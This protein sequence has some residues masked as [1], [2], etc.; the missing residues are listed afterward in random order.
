SV[1]GGAGAIG[2]FLAA[3]GLYGVVAFAVAARKRELALRMALGARPEDVVRF[4]LADSAPPIVGGALVGLALAFA[5]SRLLASLLFGLSPTDLA[6]FLGVPALLGSV[7]L[8]AVLVPARRAAA[9]APAVA[10]RSE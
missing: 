4:V 2:L 3:V 5:L 7:A 1:A 8:L 10:L 9:V 6:T